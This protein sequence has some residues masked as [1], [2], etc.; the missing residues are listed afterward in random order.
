MVEPKNKRIHI[1]FAFF[2]SLQGFFIL[3]FGTL[4]DSKIRSFV[5][6]RV[7]AL[8][9]ASNRTKNTSVGISSL[10]GLNIIR[11]LRRRRNVYH[12]SPVPN[13]SG[14]TE[15]SMLFTNI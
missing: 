10:R 5:L 13:S 4:F 12:V 15:S 3:V 8:V 7:P 6:Q 1:A 14:N 9:S 11:R 2:N